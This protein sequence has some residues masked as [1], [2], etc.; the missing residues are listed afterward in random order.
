MKRPGAMRFLVSEPERITAMLIS[1]LSH[2]RAVSRKFFLGTK[3]IDIASL[4]AMLLFFSIGCARQENGRGRFGDEVAVAAGQVINGDYFAFGRLVEISGTVNGDVYAFAGQVVIDGRVNGDVLVAGG[5]VSLS[6]VVAQDV[7]AAGGHITV[8]GTVGRNLTVSAGNVELT[9]SAL[10]RGGLVV[11]GG[12]VDV[13]SPIAGGA[14]VAAGA[15]IL[16]NKVGGDVDAAVGAL[17]ITSKA[18]IEGNVDY[19]S[20]QEASVSEG[21]RIKGKI[22]RRFPAEKPEVLP[23]IFSA[24]IVA[25][26]LFVAVSFVSTL[27]L[28][29]LSL[30][31][32]PRFHQ[33]AVTVLKKR[34]WA[35]LGIG[36]IAAVMTPVICAILFATV[37]AVPLALIATAAY[38][39]LLYWGRIF[40]ISR[41][42]E[43]II[44]HFRSGPGRTSAFVLGLI[45]YYLLAILPFVGWIV[46]PLV[47]L[48]GLGAELI[49]RKDFYVAARRH[50]LI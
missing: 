45:T 17:R 27:I 1:P 46:V 29:L 31:F 16:S 39:M 44:G 3:L 10:V 37:V 28:G 15:L 35:S 5:R 40:A 12:N 47:V 19:W 20:D 21:A 26:V 22:V 25:W 48:F 30:R 49:T 6:G 8:S 13:A 43:A 4:V 32:L 42:G 41:I 11:A 2:F 34:P 9:P 18:Q 24:F 36:F 7:R 14:K 23:A 38:L 50:D 33:S